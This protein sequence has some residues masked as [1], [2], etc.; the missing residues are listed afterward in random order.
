MQQFMQEE[1]ID[2]HYAICYI[3]NIVSRNAIHRCHRCGYIGWIYTRP[4]QAALDSRRSLST[5]FR[6]TVA[7]ES[8]CR[9]LRSGA[10]PQYWATDT[11]KVAQQSWTHMPLLL[12]NVHENVNYC[13]QSEYGR[14]ESA[15]NRG[16]I[17]SDLMDFTARSWDIGITNAV[18]VTVRCEDRLQSWWE[19]ELIKR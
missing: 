9:R 15:W 10:L 12:A 4:W 16:E 1:L 14:I 13:L 11:A 8:H 7:A 2:P 19:K 18:K 6:I 17:G 3:H 5:N